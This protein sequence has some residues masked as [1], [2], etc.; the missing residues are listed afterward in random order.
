MA[1]VPAPTPDAS[2]CPFCGLQ[3]GVTNERNRPSDLVAVTDLAYAR[4]APKWWPGNPGAL[5]V[6]PRAHVRDLYSVTSHDGHA[7]WDL[8]QQVAVAMRRSYDCDGI[9][10]RQHNE[11]A[12]GQDVWHLHVHVL[13]RVDGDRLYQRH[14]EAR[15]VAAE[16]RAPYARRLR[17]ELGLPTTF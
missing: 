14:D 17:T 2:D 5:L 8:T 12:G 16:E 9:S 4:V 10:T 15:W 11:A 7:V 1:D 13:P 6:L 3:R